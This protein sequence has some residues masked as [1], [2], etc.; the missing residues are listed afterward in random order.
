MYGVGSEWMEMG[1]NGWVCELMDGNR[2]EWIE[3]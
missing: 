3:L 2:S 1:V